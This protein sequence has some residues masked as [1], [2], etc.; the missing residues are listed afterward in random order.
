VDIKKVENYATFI[1]VVLAIFLL[2]GGSFTV[3]N[4]ARKGKEPVEL[5]KTTIRHSEWLIVKRT[6]L[7]ENLP[8][9]ETIDNPI[10]E[11]DEITVY[12]ENGEVLF[13]MEEFDTEEY[14][15]SFSHEIKKVTRWREK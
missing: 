15:S 7:T 12:D 3:R 6:L 14:E 10:G 8:V 5:Y 13:Y 1:K 9:I 2:L 11:K 4:I